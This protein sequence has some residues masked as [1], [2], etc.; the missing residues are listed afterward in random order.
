MQSHVELLYHVD[1]PTGEHQTLDEAGFE[2]YIAECG[3]ISDDMLAVMKESSQRKAPFIFEMCDFC[4]G[5]PEDIEKR[6][7]DRDSLECQVELR[8]HVKQHMQEVALFL[9]PIRE[10]ILDENEN[11]HSSDIGTQQRSAGRSAAEDLSG[12]GEE[13][14]NANCD[15]RM[16]G[17]YPGLPEAD[18]F[19]EDWPTAE[20]IWADLISDVAV[21]SPEAEVTL[22]NEHN[23]ASEAPAISRLSLFVQLK[24][25]MV[26]C[27]LEDYSDSNYLPLDALNKTITPES[28]SATLSL[29]RR[30]LS[31]FVSDPLPGL[32]C[33]QAKKVFAILVLIDQPHAIHDLTNKDN[34]TDDDLPLFQKRDAIESRSGKTLVSFQSWRE[35]SVAL[36]LHKQWAVLAP[37]LDEL[38]KEVMVDPKC[39]LPL[40]PLETI[41]PEP[42]GRLGYVV[43]QGRFHPAHQKVSIMVGAL[44]TLFVVIDLTCA[45]V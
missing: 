43:H 26:T 13:C 30:V 35:A 33:T 21:H 1:L 17:K 2:K 24:V 27:P 15:C 25:A 42:R 36:F 32:I 28:V 10:D 19:L 4:G 9:P 38:G 18:A 6:F 34:I 8:R 12:S 31:Y 20:S 45:N 22:L 3:N 14:R 11:V 16:A 5:F 23:E 29:A 37:T 7:S 39:P 40:I 44:S 41:A